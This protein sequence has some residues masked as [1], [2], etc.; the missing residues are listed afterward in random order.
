MAGAVPAPDRSLRFPVGATVTTE[1]LDGDP[2]PA[3]ARLRAA[4]PVSWIPALDAWMVTGRD[5]V[6]GAM[7]DAERFTVDDDR[8][9]TAVV[10]GDSMLSLDGAAHARHRDPFAP[11]FRPGA[12]HDQLDELL[13]GTVARLV[14]DLDPSGAEL[15]T[16]L[17]G[18]LAVEAITGLLGLEGV[19]AADV[20]GWYRSIS[21]AITDLTTGGPIDPADRAAVVELKRRVLATLDAPG[22]TSLLADL[23]AGG[24][25]DTEELASGAAVLMFG[26]IETAEGMTAN[27]LWHLLTSEGAWSALRRDRSL[28]AA[29]IEESLRLEPAAAVVDRYATVDVELGGVIIPAG[30][31]VT[32]SLLAANHDE[33]LFER[34]GVFD[35]TRSNRGLHV[36]FARGPHACLGHHLARMETR[37]AVEGLLDAGIEPRLDRARSCGPRGLVFRKPEAIW[38][39]W[40]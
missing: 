35:P 39:D 20:L 24:A 27:L 9:T 17:A 13:A 4:E 10:L 38:V 8:F 12:L 32:L 29:G 34:P 23:A 3:L 31:A 11:A 19:D 5:L 7:R 21:N 18:P 40:S 16:G 22:A 15:R 1:E 36:T 25:L 37:A 30:E 2:L 33:D 28:L 14:A 6:I 26:A